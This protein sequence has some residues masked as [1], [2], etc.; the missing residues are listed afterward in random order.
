MAT[1]KSAI[2]RAR[3]GEDARQRNNA[4]KTR[5]KGLVKEVNRQVKEGF[6]EE[7]VEIFKK[8]L[9][10]FLIKFRDPGRES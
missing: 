4:R 1:H 8:V 10:S 3:Q 6:S 7:E 2:K 9:H 5:V